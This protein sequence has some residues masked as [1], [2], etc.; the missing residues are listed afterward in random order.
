VSRRRK[1]A[2]S[3]A[4]FFHDPW[5]TTDHEMEVDWVSCL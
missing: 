2:S 3:L 5:L 1:D 4:K